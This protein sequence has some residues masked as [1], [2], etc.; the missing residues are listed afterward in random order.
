MPFH[1]TIRIG[2]QLGREWSERLHGL[3]VTNLAADDFVETT[4]EGILPDQAA[5]QG[6]IATL[7]DLNLEV[8]SVHTSPAS[9]PSV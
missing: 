5:L 3:K 1:C 9:T 4:L 7:G 2:G 6:V 8:R